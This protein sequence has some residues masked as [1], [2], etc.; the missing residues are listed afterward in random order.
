[1]YVIVGINFSKSAENFP[2]RTKMKT[3]FVFALFVV[4]NV[5]KT[6]ELYPNPA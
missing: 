6:V 3:V 4:V 5:S 1:M 2:I